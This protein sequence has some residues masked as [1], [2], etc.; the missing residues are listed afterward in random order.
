MRVGAGNPG[1]GARTTRVVTAARIAKSAVTRRGFLL[2]KKPARVCD[3]RR[4]GS[5]RVDEPRFG[6][7]SNY[8]FRFMRQTVAEGLPNECYFAEIGRSLTGPTAGKLQDFR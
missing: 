6:I 8:A 5:D 2:A 3:D 1:V 4:R 7:P